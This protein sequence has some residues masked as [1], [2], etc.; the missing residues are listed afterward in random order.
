[1]EVR[2]DVLKKGMM[3][4]TEGNYAIADS[5]RVIVNSRDQR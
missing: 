5:T 3:V 2:S 1:V 4:I